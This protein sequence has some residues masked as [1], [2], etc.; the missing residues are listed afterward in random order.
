MFLN[1]RYRLRLTCNGDHRGRGRCG[2]G[3]ATHGRQ[4]D[5]RNPLAALMCKGN[6]LSKAKEERQP[7][8]HL[9]PGRCTVADLDLGNQVLD[10]AIMR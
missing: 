10:P 8:R 5:H 6:F 7:G 1:S 2:C 9:L 4:G 3:K